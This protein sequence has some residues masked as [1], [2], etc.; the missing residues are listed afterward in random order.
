VG[1]SIIS[2][3]GKS[4]QIIHQGHYKGELWALTT[5]QSKGADN[6]IITGGDDKSIRMWDIAL[7]K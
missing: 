5:Q 7:K 1:A 6:L 3:N 2:Y 4:S